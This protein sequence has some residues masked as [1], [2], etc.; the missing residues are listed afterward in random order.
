MLGITLTVLGEDWLH[1]TGRGNPIP[2]AIPHI[3]RSNFLVHRRWTSLTGLRMRASGAGADT[4]VHL[5]TH[6]YRRGIPTFEQG[7]SLVLTKQQINPQVF[8]GFG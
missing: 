4:V 7:G 8:D 1:A 2:P 6:S 3:S 5:V